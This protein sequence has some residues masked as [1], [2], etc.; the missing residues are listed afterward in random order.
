MEDG[1][2]PAVEFNA[3]WF[4]R[5]AADGGAIARIHI[6]MLAPEAFRAMV[7]VAIPQHEEPAPLAGKVL[8][9]SLEF[10]CRGHIHSVS[11][12]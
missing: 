1:I 11:L 7:S 12:C 6:N 4:H 5:A 3:D 2:F 10:L 9:R 8:A